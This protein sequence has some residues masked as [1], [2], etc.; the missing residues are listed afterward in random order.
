MCFL[1]LYKDYQSDKPTV[2]FCNAGIQAS[3]A[4]VVQQAIFPDAE[5]RIYNGSLKEMEVRAP[6]RVS[7]GP[8]HVNN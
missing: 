2:T 3:F 8:L 4:A 7:E 5:I 1:E 6:E